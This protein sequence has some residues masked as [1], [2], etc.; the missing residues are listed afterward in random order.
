[1]HNY[2]NKNVRRRCL[3]KSRKHKGEIHL[4]MEADRKESRFNTLRALR[5]MKVYDNEHYKKIIALE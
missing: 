4:D 5:V 3:A 1:M 2:K